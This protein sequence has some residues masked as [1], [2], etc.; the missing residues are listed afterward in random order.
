MGG[1]TNPLGLRRQVLAALD[2]GEPAGSIGKACGVSWSQTRYWRAAAGAGGAVTAAPQVLS[3]AERHTSPACSTSPEGD[4]ELRVGSW[5]I[6]I[7]RVT[8]SPYT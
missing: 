5:Q 6:N 4:L 3:V 8:E 2:E 1:T 7:N